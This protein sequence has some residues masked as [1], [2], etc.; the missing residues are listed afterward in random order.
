M[1]A[2]KWA[3]AKLEVKPGKQPPRFNW[4]LV[5]RSISLVC[6]G[7]MEGHSM[8]RTRIFEVPFLTNTEEVL[9]GEEL[10]MEISEK[11]KEPKVSKRSWRDAMRDDEIVQKKQASKG[12]KSGDTLGF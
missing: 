11:R 10:I 2:Q 6:V 7:A 1:T 4:G 5:V 8:N 12:V 3:R 9:Q